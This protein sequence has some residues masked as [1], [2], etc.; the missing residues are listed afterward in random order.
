MYKHDGRVGEP[1][2]PAR[3]LHHDPISD[4]M[5]WCSSLVAK[6]TVSASHTTAILFYSYNTV[7][8]AL[9]W[10]LYQSVLLYYVQLFFFCF[11]FFYHPV[12]FLLFSSVSIQFTF[13]WTPLC[14]TVFT[15]VFSLLHHRQLLNAEQHIFVP[16]GASLT[17]FI[18]LPPA[19]SAASRCRGVKINID[20]N[21]NVKNK[22]LWQRQKPI[23]KIWKKSKNVFALSFCKCLF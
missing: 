23:I 10:Y 11:V 12:A 5:L 7:P 3:E 1:P 13:L 2:L 6:Q 8:G 22:G 16:H 20:M 19:T 15:L 4:F 21:E 18:I 17:G 9:P 14:F